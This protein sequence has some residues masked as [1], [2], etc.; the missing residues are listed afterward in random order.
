M[1]LYSQLVN[2]RRLILL[3]SYAGSLLLLVTPKDTHTSFKISTCL[4]RCLINKHGRY[5]KLLL[6]RNQDA[7]LREYPHTCINNMG[8]VFARQDLIV[9]VICGRKPGRPPFSPPQHARQS[10]FYTSPCYFSLCGGWRFHRVLYGE[11]RS[12]KM[13]SKRTFASRGWITVTLRP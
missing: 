12:L 4:A 11:P 10:I 5:M 9:D 8:N 6:L 13:T 1:T 3:C 2:I 7:C